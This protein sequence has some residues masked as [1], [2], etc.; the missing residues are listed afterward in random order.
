MILSLRTT[1][2]ADELL[3]SAAMRTFCSGTQVQKH[4]FSETLIP[5]SWE[6]FEC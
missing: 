2:F 5:K 6:T 1:V 4:W 3:L